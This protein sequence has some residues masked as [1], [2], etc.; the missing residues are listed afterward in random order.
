MVSQL[1]WCVMRADGS[2]MK[3]LSRRVVARTREERGD[4]IAD[5]LAKLVLTLLIIGLILYELISIG[6]NAVQVEEAA[7]EAARRGAIAWRDGASQLAV[8]EAVTDSLSTERGMVLEGV[9]V[10]GDQVWVT[11]TRPAPVL[12]I[13]HVGFLRGL[14]T[15]TARDDAVVRP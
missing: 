5:G 11:L 6:V 10:E 13:D 1:K 12:L 9:S 3:K 7:G 14:V 4:I 8:E 2:R 15:H